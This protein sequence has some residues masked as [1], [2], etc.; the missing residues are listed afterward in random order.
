MDT[1]HAPG[2]AV[3]AIES[4]R[5]SPQQVRATC[6]RYWSRSALRELANVVNHDGN[7]PELADEPDTV[8]LHR[9][10]TIE[11]ARQLSISSLN[12][13]TIDVLR[14]FHERALAKDKDK[15][16]SDDMDMGGLFLGNAGSEEDDPVVAAAAREK[17]RRNATDNI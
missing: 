2:W 12:T 4:A 1:T 16:W 17:R 3:A 10:L 9:T 15:D 8:P 13:K 7:L 5:K 11:I 14:R 6:E